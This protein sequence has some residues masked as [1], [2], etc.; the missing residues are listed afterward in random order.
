MKL[1]CCLIN[2]NQSDSKVQQPTA[3]C[4]E[5]AEMFRAKGMFSKI[6][7]D[8]LSTFELNFMTT[9]ARLDA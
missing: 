8:I 1:L 3:M 4:N 2:G 9:N 7:C 6:K 5:K